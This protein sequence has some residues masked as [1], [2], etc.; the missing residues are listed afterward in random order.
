ML[1]EIVWWERVVNP[2]HELPGISRSI[3]PF[4]NH[5][6][7][8]GQHVVLL[9]LVRGTAI[10]RRDNAGQLFDGRGYFG[11]MIGNPLTV[12]RQAAFA[13]HRGGSAFILVKQ[14]APGNVRSGIF[15]V[16]RLLRVLSTVMLHDNNAQPACSCS[17]RM[18]GHKP[19]EIRHNMDTMTH[20]EVSERL[21]SACLDRSRG[22]HAAASYRPRRSLKSED[23]S[24]LSRAKAPSLGL[25]S[26]SRKGRTS[27]RFSGGFTSGNSS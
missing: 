18:G 11:L 14:R 24:L 13:S 3:D 21:L 5:R 22:A 6:R 16:L 27:V 23:V 19:D 12:S 1:V 8:F 26:G 4:L 20:L 10:I 15:Q 2:D 9:K 17:R 25:R 7:E